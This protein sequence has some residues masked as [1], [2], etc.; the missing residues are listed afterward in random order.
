MVFNFEG[1]G[2]LFGSL[3]DAHGTLWLLLYV[4]SAHPTPVPVLKG[5]AVSSNRLATWSVEALTVHTPAIQ[6]ALATAE[7]A[8]ARHHWTGIG[9]DGWLRVRLNTPLD[10]F[11]P[12]SGGTAVLEA[13]AVSS[14]IPRQ[15]A[16]ITHNRCRTSAN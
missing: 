9:F 6:H 12:T 5:P 8:G 3:G 1:S 14:T 11:N 7:A 10:I 16:A 2:D 13:S 15:Y 4:A